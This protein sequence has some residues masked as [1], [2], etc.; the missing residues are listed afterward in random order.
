[1]PDWD[2]DSPLLRKNLTQVLGEIVRAAQ[3]REHPTLGS[4]RRWQ[5]LF[6][7]NLK[8][9]DSRFVGAFRG[10]PGL[11][12]VQVR[13]GGHNGVVDSEKPTKPV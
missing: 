12:N 6:M 2:V 9:P 8:V 3:R 10:E 4:A 7:K 5:T 13:V 1:V 11:E